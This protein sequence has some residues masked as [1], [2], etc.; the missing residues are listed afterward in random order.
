MLFYFFMEEK[1]VRFY[2]PLAKRYYRKL[3]KEIFS[4]VFSITRKIFPN[5]AL[6]IPFQALV[7]IFKGEEIN[8][9]LIL[10]NTLILFFWLLIIFSLL[11]LYFSINDIKKEENHVTFYDEYLK[12][13]WHFFSVSKTK[14][15]F[16]A[17]DAIV[18]Y[19][20]KEGK[21][22][23]EIYIKKSYQIKDKLITLNSI[24][25]YFWRS[26]TKQKQIP[27][28]VSYE[29]E[30]YTEL[31]EMHFYLICKDLKDIKN[32]ISE[33]QFLEI[34][35]QSPQLVFKGQ[36]EAENTNDPRILDNYSYQTYHYE[37]IFDNNFAGSL[38]FKEGAVIIHLLDDNH[39]D[40]VEQLAENLDATY[41]VI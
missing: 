15:L 26:Q 11:G 17:I 22:R 25:L 18:F 7:Q 14:I 40:W 30:L 28:F 6:L 36:T 2:H 27:F 9:T 33:E 38:E 31:Y 12:I 3:S 1:R 8:L 37:I 16:E 34:A 23:S 32:T 13:D 10:E 4:F 24:P 35:N 5:I 29:P 21:L 20:L 39:E 41:E 19:P